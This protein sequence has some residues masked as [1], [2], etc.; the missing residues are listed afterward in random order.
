MKK[1]ETWIVKRFWFHTRKSRMKQLL[2]SEIIEPDISSNFTEIITFSMIIRTNLSESAEKSCGS[3][4]KCNFSSMHQGNS[5]SSSGKI[6]RN[7]SHRKIRSL[8]LPVQRTHRFRIIV[9]SQR[10]I[11]SASHIP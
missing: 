11:F 3:Y 8:P 7:S 2:T 5:R 10:Q 1:T 4:F 6:G 9:F